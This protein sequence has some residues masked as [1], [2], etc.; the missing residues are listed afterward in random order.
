M[1]RRGFSRQQPH[2]I[3][4]PL[5]RFHYF[6]ARI[7]FFHVEG[8]HENT[9]FYWQRKLREAA[10][11]KIVESGQQNAEIP[12]GWTACE[13]IKSELREEKCE[14]GSLSI[15]IGKCRIKIDSDVNSELLTSV[16]RTLIRLC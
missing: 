15:E 10:C 3:Y 9:Y 8:L 1:R 7:F 11:E 6:T 12:Q 14:P 5:A 13:V 2:K 16:C 4:V